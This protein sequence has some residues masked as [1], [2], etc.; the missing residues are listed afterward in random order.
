MFAVPQKFEVDPISKGDMTKPMIMS[1]AR[2]LSALRSGQANFDV[3]IF[4]SDCAMCV[5]RN[6]RTQLLA[7]FES[8]C[9]LDIRRSVE[10]PNVIRSLPFSGKSG[11]SNFHHDK[12]PMDICKS[13]I[14][15]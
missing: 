2:I 15:S 11:I 13:D 12:N 1:L 4:S 9:H 6:I 7:V 8:S 3:P 5:K 14:S 10:L